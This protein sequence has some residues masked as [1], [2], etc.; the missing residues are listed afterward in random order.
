LSKKIMPKI[1]SRKITQ[2]ITFSGPHNIPV[3]KYKKCS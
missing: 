2:V 1:F 3:S